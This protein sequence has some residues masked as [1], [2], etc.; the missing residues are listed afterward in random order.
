MDLKRSVSGLVPISLFHLPNKKTT[1]TNRTVLLVMAIGTMK[2]NIQAT[3]EDYP[4]EYL[5]ILSCLRAV[6]ATKFTTAEIIF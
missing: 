1:L 2:F 6:I 3:V 4:L 5:F